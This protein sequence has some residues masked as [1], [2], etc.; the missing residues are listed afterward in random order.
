MPKPSGTLQIQN[1]AERWSRDWN[2]QFFASCKGGYVKGVYERDVQS[3]LA[4]RVHK[5][6]N[7]ASWL[8]CPNLHHISSHCAPY[9]GHVKGVHEGGVKSG[10]M[11]GM[12]KCLWD[13]SLDSYVVFHPIA[14]CYIPYIVG[15]WRGMHKRGVQRHR[16]RALLLVVCFRLS[17]M[18]TW[19][20]RH[21]EKQIPSWLRGIEIWWQKLITY[22]NEI[23]H[24]PLENENITLLSPICG[25]VKTPDDCIHKVKDGLRNF[26][27]EKK[28]SLRLTSKWGKVKRDEAKRTG[29]REAE[30]TRDKRMKQQPQTH[31]TRPKSFLPL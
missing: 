31:E 15:A 26:L 25:M 8:R 16:T 11:K 27:K 10:C 19:N 22:W 9:R 20:R 29:L 17:R 1:V 21:C 3:G 14:L 28:G 6:I 5:G 2:Q 12:P 13:L 18:V 24:Q 23:L 30:H 7:T 4:N